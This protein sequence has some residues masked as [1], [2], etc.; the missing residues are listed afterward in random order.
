MEVTYPN[1]MIMNLLMYSRLFDDQEFTVNI[2][3]V[4]KQ[5]GKKMLKSWQNSKFEND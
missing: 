5:K 4:D 3:Y 2:M 1:D